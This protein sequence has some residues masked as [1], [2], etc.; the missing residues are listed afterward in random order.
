MRVSYRKAV[1]MKE[2]P[3]IT[4][5]KQKLYEKMYFGDKESNHER[6]ETR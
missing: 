2:F 5:D 1:Y 3:I 4:K 6:F